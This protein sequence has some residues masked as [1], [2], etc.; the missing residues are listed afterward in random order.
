[1]NRSNGPLATRAS[2]CS[3]SARAAG[4]RAAASAGVNHGA[5]TERKA[6]CRP[7]QPLI[8]RRSVAQTKLL[9][10]WRWSNSCRVSISVT[11]EVTR[12]GSRSSPRMVA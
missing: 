7:G 5:I 12:R 8:V 3:Q 6:A 10:G 1:V 9:T 11:S 4:R 2:R